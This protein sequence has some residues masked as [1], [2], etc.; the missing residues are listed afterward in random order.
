MS[1]INEFQLSKYFNLKE[2]ECPCCH[3]VKLSHK[4][5]MQLV[6]LRN[7]IGLPLIIT[8]GFR[9]DRYNE[10]VGGVKGS[11]HKMGMA[12]DVTIQNGKLTELYFLAKELKFTGIGLYP[13]RYFLHLDVREG[14]LLEWTGDQ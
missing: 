4:L 12:A 8:S 3:Q 6:F 9:C 10:K 13:K 14:D 7:D 1:K 11:Y 2:F 5:F